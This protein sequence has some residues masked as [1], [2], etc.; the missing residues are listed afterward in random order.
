MPK[1]R[2]KAYR[3]PFVRLDGLGACREGLL[4]GLGENALPADTLRLT[5]ALVV[6]LLLLRLLL[7]LLFRLLRRSGL[8]LLDD[9]RHIAA[10]R[11][12][13]GFVFRGGGLELLI[14]LLVLLV[15]LVL[16]L[17][18][19]ALLFLYEVLLLPALLIAS[20]VPMCAPV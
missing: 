13:R 11:L 16:G 8:D 9:R 10:L 1:H 12:H 19:D 15:L 20:R 18:C 17:L 3:G 6:G 14:V 5:L 2:Q 7:R 4:P